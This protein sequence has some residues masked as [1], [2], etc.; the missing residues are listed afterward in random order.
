MTQ[1]F[2]G[3]AS[4][5]AILQLGKAI[6]SPSE[7]LLSDLSG[8]S[9]HLR[10][11][12]LKVLKTL[13]EKHGE[14][15]SKDELIDV[16]WPNVTVSDDSLTQ[17]VAD[18]RKVLGDKERLILRTIP[19]VGYALFASV[20]ERDSLDFDQREN[21]LT[22]VLEAPKALLYVA[23]V[24]ETLAYGDSSRLLSHVEDI[25]KKNETTSYN[26]T[27]HV[28]LSCA[29]VG[30]AVAIAFE[31]LAV[32]AKAFQS[33]VLTKISICLECETNGLGVVKLT[34]LA[35]LSTGRS[36][37]SIILSSPAREHLKLTIEHDVEDL[38]YSNRASCGGGLRAFK[39]TERRKFAASMAKVDDTVFAT[40]AVIPLASRTP[41]ADQGM[42]GQLIADDI[43]TEVSSSPDLRVIA[44]LSTTNLCVREVD[45]ASIANYLNANFI[46]SG[47]YTTSGSTLRITLELSDVVS[48]TIM[49]SERLE[50]EDVEITQGVEAIANVV[51]SIRR[52]I[53][54]HETRK[55]SRFSLN[56]LQ[57]YTL[58]IGA[59]NLM[60][61]LSERDFLKAREVL[62]EL[63][64]RCPG[65]PEPLAWIGRW[66]VLRVQQG[67]GMD[68]QEESRSAL[69]FTAR[70]LAIDPDCSLSLSSEGAVLVNLTHDLDKAEDSYSRALEG[71]PNDANCRLLRGTLYAFQGKGIEAQKD[72]ELS[73]RLAPLDPHRFMYLALTAGANLAAQDYERAMELAQASYRLN[74]SHASTLRILAVTQLRLGENAEA[75]KTGQELMRLQPELRVNKWLSTSPSGRYDIGKEFAAALRDVGVPQ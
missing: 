25:A 26:G 63:V 41:E 35:I 62:D 67:W 15:I 11:Q 4:N 3:N 18:I 70:A 12:S 37:D 72:C 13:A 71:N 19:K 57:N 1:P 66:H 46:V 29:N 74:R 47:S 2:V 8:V 75:M 34:D 61:R 20:V 36:N 6:Y 55:M 56:S 49:W 7:E 27:D 51:A 58:L 64:L 22:S 21:V 59:I 33:G 60:H 31:T 9:V 10:P 45:A 39:I 32:V 42:M 17:C 68:L 73:L 43:V 53:S 69:I 14:I 16:V 44:R 65:H 30:D 38:G 5:S 52:T 40:I 50:F 24:L 23:P 48:Q 54:A 28:L